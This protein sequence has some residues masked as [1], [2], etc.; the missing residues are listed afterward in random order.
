VTAFSATYDDIPFDTDPCDPI[1]AVIAHPGWGAVG[2]GFVARSGKRPLSVPGGVE[3]A[4]YNAARS[5]AYAA[6][7]EAARALPND[8]AGVGFVLGDRNDDYHLACWDLDG[9]RDP[10]TGAIATW[11]R[12]I[13]DFVGTYAEASLSRTGLHAPFWVAPGGVPIIRDALA[14]MKPP[15][16]SLDC[17]VWTAG[18]TVAGRA[19]KAEL[20]L[21]NRYIALTGWRLREFQE[22]PALID[23]SALL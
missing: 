4:N 21:S 1:R 8:G 5:G 14:K 18:S 22:G 15:G 13:L 10:V 17:A 19:S 7:V 6:A 16:T 20:Y 3:R 11:A 2:A 12:R 23:A 9:A